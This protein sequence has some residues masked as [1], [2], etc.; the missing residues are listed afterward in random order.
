MIHFPKI[1]IGC[2]LLACGLLA[3][4]AWGTEKILPGKPNELTRSALKIN[5]AMAEKLGLTFETAEIEI[6][7]LTRDYHFLWI[8]DLHVIGEDLGEV[9]EK[10]LAIVRSRI[11]DTFRNP[12]SGLTSLEIWQQLPEVMNQSGADG[13]LFGGDICD[14]ATLSSLQALKEGMARLTI[15]FMYVRADHDVSPWWLATNN[16]AEIAASHQMI[17][18][19]EPLLAMEFPDLLVV[20]WN[21]S[22][23][24]LAE[25]GLRRFKELCA[26]GKPIILVTHVPLQS[27]AEE[28]FDAL[29]RANDSQGRSLLW[30]SENNLYVPNE[31]TQEFLDMVYAEK[32]PVK[33]VLAAHLHFGWHGMLTTDVSQHLFIPALQ[34]NI[35]VVHLKAKNAPRRCGFRAWL[36]RLSGREKR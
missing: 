8:A 5:E 12:H 14:I 33:A 6:D 15:P 36:R 7:G 29:C 17:C 34:G 26:K 9:A 18:D 21:N 30:G 19:N 28:S 1:A 31:T 25:E 23:G 24:N 4:M 22:T 32:S 35:G 27:K 3:S 13:V 11:N 16:V 10:N 2:L 20:G